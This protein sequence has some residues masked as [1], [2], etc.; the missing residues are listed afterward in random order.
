M[1]KEEQEYLLSRVF[2]K[3]VGKRLTAQHVDP[4][5]NGAMFNHI[6]PAFHDKENFCDWLMMDCKEKGIPTEQKV[7]QAFVRTLTCAPLLAD[8]MLYYYKSREA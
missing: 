8:A 4:L 7:M 2:S 3:S 6:W 1:N 5:D